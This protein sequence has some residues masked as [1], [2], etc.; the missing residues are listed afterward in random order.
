MA[1]REWSMLPWSMSTRG[2][3]SQ[4]YL[5]L[6]G[7]A[8][9]NASFTTFLDA[10]VFLVFLHLY[11]LIGVDFVKP[12]FNLKS[13]PGILHQMVKIL[14]KVTFPWLISALELDLSFV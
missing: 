7:G 6:P 8:F 1:E 3:F 4:F 11:T 14:Q 9:A 10:N 5:G 2:S 13:N 12:L